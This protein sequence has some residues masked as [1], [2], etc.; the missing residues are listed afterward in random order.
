[1]IISE[2][3]KCYEENRA[4]YWTDRDGGQW[5]AFEWKPEWWGDT[6]HVRAL[7]QVWVWFVQGALR[8][9]SGAGPGRTRRCM[10]R[11][12]VTAV[13]LHQA[14]P[15]W[16]FISCWMHG[17][18]YRLRNFKPW[19][20]PPSYYFILIDR[21]DRIIR[22]IGKKTDL[23]RREW[24]GVRKPD[25]V[26]GPPFVIWAPW[27]IHQPGCNFSFLPWKRESWRPPPSPPAYTAVRWGGVWKPPH[28]PVTS[29]SCPR[30][31]FILFL[32]AEK[33]K[34]KDV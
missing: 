30:E 33:Q 29:G 20:G 2:S 32:A 19:I 11:D 5:C 15:G 34:T 12:E 25:G 17:F 31:S 7:K 9:A 21:W 3:L 27:A 23:A 24:F 10:G 18:P 4:G 16:E 8:E 6:G 14:D 28:C 13:L 22:K 26:Q 1:M